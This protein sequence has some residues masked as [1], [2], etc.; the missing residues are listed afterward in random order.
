MEC[1]C[2]TV[3]VSKHECE[4]HMWM[5]CG[6]SVHVCVCVCVCVC[7]LPLPPQCNTMSPAETMLSG[8][9]QKGNG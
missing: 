5:I 7:D 9:F 1:T 2:V 4:K 3:H 8:L 6:A